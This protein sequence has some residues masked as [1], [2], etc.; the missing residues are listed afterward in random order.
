MYGF[1]YIKNHLHALEYGDIEMWPRDKEINKLV[2][3]FCI[4][5]PAAVTLWKN[6]DTHILLSHDTIIT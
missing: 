2:T 3:K 5:L 1:R 6:L 4:A